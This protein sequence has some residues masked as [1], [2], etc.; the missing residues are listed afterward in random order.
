MASNDHPSNLKAMILAAGF[1]TRLRPLSLNLPK[2][3]FPIMNR[4]LL[5]HSIDLLKSA[6]ITDIAINVH[7]H[8]EKIMEA[9]GRGE[10]LG[11]RLNYSVEEKILG[12][13]GGIKAAQRYLDGG[14]FIVINSDVLVNIDLR[15]VLQFHRDKG[16]C[17]TLVVRQDNSPESYDPIEIDEDGRVVH[18]IG[19]S[20]MN[21]PDNTSR[22][23]FTGIQIMEPEIFERIPSGQF[24]GT[25]KDVFPQM[26]ED[27]CPVFGYLH[28]DYWIDTGKPETYRQAHV[29][30][31]D[32]KVRLKHPPSQD[33]KGPLIIPPVMIG[34]NCRIAQNAQVGPY[35]VLGDECNVRQGAVIEHSVC[36]DKVT[37]GIDSTVQRSILGEGVR[38]DNQQQVE[39]Q[40]IVGPG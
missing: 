37:L 22:V 36:W 10:E 14:P 24:C 16:S 15:Q 29:D 13:A 7:H 18:F 33:P 2:P 38:I 39:G 35:A 28:R 20:S 40:S 8:P 34:K 4:P 6:G 23:M 27:G 21:L 25:A 26:I 5:A 12:T 3:M 19:A 30:A 31:L 32:G 9:F 11:A 1:G 17:L